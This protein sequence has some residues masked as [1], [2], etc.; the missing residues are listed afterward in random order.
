MYN[1]IEQISRQFLESLGPPS[2]YSVA[3]VLAVYIFIVFGRASS[4]R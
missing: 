3:A 1:L 2:L 4:G